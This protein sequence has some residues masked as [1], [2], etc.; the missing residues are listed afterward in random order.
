MMFEHVHEEQ[1]C[2]LLGCGTF[3][4]ENEVCHLAKLIHHRHDCIKSP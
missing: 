4:G 3:L 2:H 1:P